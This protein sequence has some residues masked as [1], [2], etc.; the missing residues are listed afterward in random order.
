MIICAIGLRG[1]PNV[2][3]GIETHCGYLYP[4][5]AALRPNDTIFVC[6]RSHYIGKQR[7]NPAPG[8]TVVP[9]AAIHNNYLTSSVKRVLSISQKLGRFC[10]LP[11]PVGSASGDLV[12]EIFQRRFDSVASKLIARQ[13]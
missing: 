1:F 3:G 12:R 4:R 8:V 2:A 6:G 10:N 9:V 5:L 11:G 13:S 7:Y